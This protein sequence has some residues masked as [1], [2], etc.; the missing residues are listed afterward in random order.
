MDVD[1]EAVQKAGQD[2]DTHDRTKVVN[3]LLAQRK[4]TSKVQR[5]AMATSAVKAAIGWS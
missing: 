5:V 3:Q 2:G 1:D 4:D